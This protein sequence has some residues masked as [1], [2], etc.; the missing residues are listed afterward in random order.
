MTS[1]DPGVAPDGLPYV[2]PGMIWDGV[3]EYHNGR[4]SEAAG[5]WLLRM[6]GDGTRRF[7][8]FLGTGTPMEQFRTRTELG[9]EQIGVTFMNPGFAA[10]YRDVGF[11]A[12]DGALTLDPVNQFFYT[13]EFRAHAARYAQHLNAT[14]GFDALLTADEWKR[15]VVKQ[16]MSA[17]L[18]SAQRRYNIW[19][20][21]DPTE[22]IS[23][24]GPFGGT[25]RWKRY[26]QFYKDIHTS[27]CGECDLD[28]YAQEFFFEADLAAF[29]SLW[30]Q[31]IIY[32][33]NHD[34]TPWSP[35]IFDVLNQADQTIAEYHDELDANYDYLLR[36]YAQVISVQD[37]SPR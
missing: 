26:E 29:K 3:T 20:E 17:L 33:S 25:F 36:H 5:S 34:T 11:L 30:R 23:G 15:L 35:Q 1:H 31:G 9:W 37:R 12:Y 4:P 27:L 14:L 13:N 24:S 10:D 28:L 32:S 8:E 18:G 2:V 16:T 21:D 22:L 6:Y 19:D 7:S